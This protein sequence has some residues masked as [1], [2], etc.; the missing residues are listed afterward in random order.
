MKI[1]NLADG[2]IGFALGDAFGVP[3][4]FRTREEMNRVSNIQEM[5]GY[6]TYNVPKGT[7]SD[8]TS[9]TLATIDSIVQQG[10][11]NTEDI[12]KKF[13][14]WFRKNEYTATGNAFDIG[15]T[16][17]QALA[18]YELNLEKAVDC[19]QTGEM[20]NGNGSLMRMLPIAYYIYYKGI[21]DCKEIY[22]IVKDVSSITHAHEVSILG[23]Y[24]YVNLVVQLLNGE[25]SVDAHKKIK[26]LDYGFFSKNSLTRY[27]RI[28]KGRIEDLRY[29]ELKSSG[30]IVDTLEC[31]FWLFLNSNNYNQTIIR[32][33]A[34]GGDTDTI[35][36]CVGG[37][38]GIYYGIESIDEN[39]KKE[40]KRYDYIINL[41]EKF[42]NAY[43]G[44]ENRKSEK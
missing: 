32:A 43:I 23:C 40:L 41:C 8:D 24:I 15:R 14:K 21:K 25:K 1:N 4:E 22:E 6:G 33:V 38:V 30:Y 39:W 19:G 44:K 31:V 18:Q 26:E 12:A 36:A 28:L 10:K 9:M 29:Q 17:F 20:D 27:E 13:L 42:D 16:T 2:I 5:I 3:Y 34:L 7:W 11:I 35:A 37:L